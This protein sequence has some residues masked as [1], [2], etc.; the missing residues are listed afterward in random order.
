[1]RF[2]GPRIARLRSRISG[3]T[4]SGIRSSA[5]LDDPGGTRTVTPRG[6]TSSNKL[7]AGTQS[8]DAPAPTPF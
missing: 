6:S 8:K 4:V 3:P 2:A 7:L 5:S 1:M